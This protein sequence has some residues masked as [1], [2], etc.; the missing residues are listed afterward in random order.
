VSSTPVRV[1]LLFSN[2]GATVVS[3]ITAASQVTASVLD[4]AVLDLGNAA[5]SI[6]ATLTNQATAASSGG[7]GAAV[8]VAT[9]R[10]NAHDGGG[11][12]ASFAGRL[13]SASSLK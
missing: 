2:P 10:A 11:S 9:L 3:E 5:A 8:S 6:D 13:L 4:G 12:A 1:G 7:G